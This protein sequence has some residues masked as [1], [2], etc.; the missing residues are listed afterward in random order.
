MKIER[1]KRLTPGYIR[2]HDFLSMRLVLLRCTASAT[3]VELVYFK[4]AGTASR[5]ATS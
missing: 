5:M 1:E 4:K 3:R 2:P